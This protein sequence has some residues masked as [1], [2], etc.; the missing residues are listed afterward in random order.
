MKDGYLI[1]YTTGTEV[2]AT[3]EELQAVQPF[4]KNGYPN[5]RFRISAL[6]VPLQKEHLQFY[7]YSYSLFLPIRA[8][9]RLPLPTGKDTN[10]IQPC[11]SLSSAVHTSD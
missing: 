6:R 3:P 9:H 8:V 11:K 10:F 7:L 4:S 1:D 5:N 2:R